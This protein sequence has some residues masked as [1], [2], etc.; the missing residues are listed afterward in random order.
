M[1][2]QGMFVAASVGLGMCLLA[3]TAHAGPP[4][5]DVM[6]S[7]LTSEAAGLVE[8]VAVRRCW[9]RNG[10]RY[11]RLRPAQ[12]QSYDPFYAQATRLYRALILGTG[13]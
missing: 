11:C 9:T 4:R 10:K 5:P 6:G 3:V 12:R 13:F 8:T 1:N 2:K 7:T